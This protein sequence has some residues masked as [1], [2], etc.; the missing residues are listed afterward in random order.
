MVD[1]QAALYGHGC[2]KAGDAKVTFGTGAFAL[3]LTGAEIVRAP[4]IGLLPTVAWKT[5]HDAVYAVEGGVYDAGAAI[6]WLM[7]IGIVANLGELQA[8]D[9]GPMIERGLAFVPALS[10]LACP[11]W[12]RSAAG[13]W[14]GM[15]ADTS[16]RDL[17][18]AALEGI[19]LRV[20]QVLDAMARRVALSA[21]LSI[22][23]GLSR[24]PAFARFLADATGRR[25]ETRAMDELTVFGCASLAALALG[26]SLPAPAGADRAFDPRDAD[27]NA[28]RQR[29]ADAVERSRS[30]R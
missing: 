15:T 14:R 21:T 6:E 10:G 26:A 22:D 12:D 9:G 3:A 1:Q 2:R 11:Y 19:A 20:G 13:L 7:R 8:F 28:W 30:W 29:F 18:Q 5:P 17:A 24:S 27:R 25:V 4:E 16:R 23:G